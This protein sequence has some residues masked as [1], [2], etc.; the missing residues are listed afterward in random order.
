M[1]P[2][3]GVIAVEQLGLG[4]TAEPAIFQLRLSASRSPAPS[5][6][7]MNGGVRWAS[8]PSRNARPAR[9]AGAT[10]AR[11]VY[12]ALRTTSRPAR[13]SCAVHWPQQPGQ[14][15]RLDEV[16]LVLAVPQLELPAVPVARDVHE[17]R[18][19]GG[20]ADLLDAV[21]GRQPGAR[22][23]RRRRASAR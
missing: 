11:N 20:V 12:T 19:A 6:W 7:P 1:R 22:R 14:H 4:A 9:K 16:G 3:L 2:A 13:S 23:G 18:G 5:P 15:P 10:R 8:S 21:P 17:R